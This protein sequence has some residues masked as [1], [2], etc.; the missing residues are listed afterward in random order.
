MSTRTTVLA[1]VV[2]LVVGTCLTTAPL[3]R[4][5]HVGPGGVFVTGHDPDFH[6]FRGG[7]HQGAI[8]M[9][10]KAVAYVTFGHDEP[11]LL[12]VT[13][14]RD[15]GEA[16]SDPRRGMDAAGFS[17][18]VADYGSGSPG[19]LDFHTVGFSSYDVV[20]VASDH[21]GWL[22]QEELD[23]L[24][25]RGDEVRQYVNAGGG[26]VVLSQGGDNRLTTCCELQF[27]PFLV[28]STELG[29]GEVGFT[30][31]P[32][33]AAMGLSDSDVNGNASHLH[34]TSSGG[35]DV[36]DVDASGRILS[37]ATR[38]NFIGDNGVAPAITVG[39]ATVVEG[40]AGVVPATFTV[41]LSRADPRDVITVEYATADGSAV[42]GEDFEP[43]SGTLSFPIGETTQTVTVDVHGDS[44]FE[45]DEH[46][47]LELANAVEAGIIDGHGVATIA[48][49]D[50]ANRPPVAVDD[51]AATVEGQAL[52]IPS[53]T[54]VANDTD[55]D[56]DALS[57]VAVGATPDTHG[58]VASND[59]S[60]TYTPE[61]GYVGPASF[62]YTVAD[63]DGGTA[64]ATVA[65]EVTPVVYALSGG[66]FGYRLQASLLGF[67]LSSGPV[68]EVVLP[69]TGG[70]PFTAAA[71]AASTPL[72]LGTL[73]V[74]TEGV[75]SGAD[76]HVASE[77][78][79][80]TAQ[81]RGRP[82]GGLRLEL[83]HS[84][85]RTTPAGST[86]ATTIA[87]LVIGS[88]TYVNL[89]PEPGTRLVVPGVGT[90][91]LNEQVRDDGP[92]HSAITVNAVHLHLLSSPLASSD[93]VLAQSRCGMARQG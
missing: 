68:P 40:S 10:Q 71:A 64:M 77:A 52:V 72:R 27:L 12:L 73:A 39:D 43:V 16:Y 23:I 62:T 22:R 79:V 3:A 61:A 18:D 47:S 86:G 19:L 38:G 89:T 4:A 66:A 31:T 65:V 28:T 59:H 55:A 45:P 24:N 29:Q 17:Y 76:A 1:A 20:V 44:T 67:P 87:R 69:P 78:Q 83:A 11:S 5:A 56:G 88:T 63:G 6:A 90:L 2:G 49:D 42:S 53:T 75:A 21:G 36:I 48:N 58:S 70:G 9:L 74:S 93:V 15:A 35:M 33:G 13:G 37:L 41:A 57:V 7:N 32:A 51:T 50:T 81:A 84:H 54:L 30:V 8:N 92:G 85:C 34:F 82:A 25:Q 80:T 14:L 26:L 46:F 60:V 91:V